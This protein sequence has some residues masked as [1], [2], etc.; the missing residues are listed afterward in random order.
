[1]VMMEM[2]LLGSAELTHLQRL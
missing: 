2:A 1:M